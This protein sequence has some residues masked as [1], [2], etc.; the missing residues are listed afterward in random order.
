MRTLKV[1]TS[2]FTVSILSG[3]A[4]GHFAMASR[5]DSV[6]FGM[7]KAEVMAV[8]GAPLSV[9]AIAGGEDPRTPPIRMC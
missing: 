1:V 2:L 4:T 8:V 9:S 7:S 3:C 5:L 6:T